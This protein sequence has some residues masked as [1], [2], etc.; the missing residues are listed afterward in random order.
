MRLFRTSLVGV[1]AVSAGV[2]LALPAEGSSAKPSAPRSVHAV[3]ANA[4]VQVSWAKP[5]STGGS[6]ETK[7]VVTS[8]PS[9][10]SCTTTKLTC[11]VT[12]LKNATA[13][14]FSVVAY[15]K[16]G[17]GPRSAVSNKVTPKVKTASVRTLVV[18]PSTGLINGETVKVSGTGFTP[19]DSVYILECLATATGQ[20]GCDIQGIP[21]PV[22]VTSAGT[23]PLMTFKV[24]TGTIGS[25][26]CGTTVANASACAIVAANISVSDAGAKVIS[27][28]P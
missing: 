27:F 6:P 19:R 14:S 13:Y 1:L 2:L 4:S 20:S 21:T 8:T 15:N 12:N 7:Y 23:I 28:K 3:A 5:S 18:T 22:T 25:G 10:K 16:Y 26:K 11:V 17:A 24:V 9:S